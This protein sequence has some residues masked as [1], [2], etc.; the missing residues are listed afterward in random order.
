METYLE[1]AHTRGEQVIHQGKISLWSLSPYL[2]LGLVFLPIFGLGLVFWAAAAIRYWTTELAVTNKR[3]IAK[4]GFISRST[5]EINLHKVESIQVNQNIFG[6]MLNFGSIIVSGAGNP[7]API[8]GISDPLAFRR[9]CVEAQD[10][11]AR[12]PAA[13]PQMA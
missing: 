1:S 4:S 3:V 8:T 5:V 9:A 2:L 7:Q 12:P 6:R 13:A 10:S 11:H